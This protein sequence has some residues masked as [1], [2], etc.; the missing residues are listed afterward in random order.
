VALV[1]LRVENPW[2]NTHTIE[3]WMRNAGRTIDSG[4]QN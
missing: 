3:E 1:L 2:P 4:R